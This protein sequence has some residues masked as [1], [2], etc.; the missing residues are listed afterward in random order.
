MGMLDR[1][2]EAL[3]LIKEQI[4]QRGYKALLID[5]IIGAG[6]MVPSPH[7]DI[8]WDELSELSGGPSDGKAEYRRHISPLAKNQ[9]P[10]TRNQRPVSISQ[11]QWEYAYRRIQFRILMKR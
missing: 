3:P 6:A 5:V 10:E 7:S 1:R 9:E 11:E 8:G 2:E 4:E